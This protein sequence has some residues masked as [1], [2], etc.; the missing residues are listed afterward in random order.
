[1]K[2]AEHIATLVL[3]ACLSGIAL[4][5]EEE[6]PK[7]ARNLFEEDDWE[8]SETDEKIENGKALKVWL[9]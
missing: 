6:T 9:Q 7:P 8:Q 3:L 4:T 2:Y 5:S 1:M